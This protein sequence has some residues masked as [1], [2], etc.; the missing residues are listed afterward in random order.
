MAGLAAQPA[1]AAYPRLRGEHSRMVMVI[2]S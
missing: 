2:L 1:I